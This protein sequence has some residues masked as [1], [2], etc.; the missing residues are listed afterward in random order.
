MKK[1]ALIAGGAIIGAIAGYLYWDNIGCLSGTC[2]IQSSPY[3]STA[4][5]TLLGGLAVSWVKDYK[6]KHK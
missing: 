4:Y 1:T 2:M 6:V 5:G 3:L